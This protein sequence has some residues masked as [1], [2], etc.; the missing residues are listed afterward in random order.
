MKKKTIN[1]FTLVEM[2]IVI[3]II[4]I[5]IAAL[6][7]R[8]QA[9]Q[10][11]ARDV[12]RKTAL[13][14]IQTAIVTYQGDKWKWPAIDSGAKGWMAIS[15]IS[16]ALRV[17]WMSSVP[18]DP[19]SSNKVTWFLSGNNET[20]ID[21][22]QYWYLVTKRNWTDNGGFVL[23]AHTEVEWW[24][25]R[26]ACASGNTTHKT[27]TWWYI[28]NTNDINEIQLCTEFVYDKNSSNTCSVSGWK[29]TYNLESELRYITVY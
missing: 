23:M 1:A 19:I 4:G 27:L 14:Q 21:D 6:L 22:W 2:L 7:P 15:G 9:A 29:C 20:T 24:S 13:S 11:R 25:N 16:E 17:A 5:L 12:S 28:K 26:V 3:V 8:M 18:V 10:W